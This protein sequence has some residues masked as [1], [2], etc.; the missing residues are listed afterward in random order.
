MH[1]PKLAVI[2]AS[3]F[4]K[5]LIRKGQQLGFEVHAFAWASKDAGEM[6]ADV[7]H[8]ISIV[9]KEAI[10]AV[11]QKESVVA[12]CSIGSDL[13]IHTVNH[14]Q[15]ALGIPCNPPETDLLATNKYEM[16]KAFLAAGVPCPKFM[17]LSAPPSEATLADMRWPLIVKP[18]DRSGSRGIYQCAS[19]DELC[20]AVGF[21]CEQSFEKCAIVEETIAGTEYSCESI[22]FAGEHYALALTK[23]YTTGSPHFIETGHTEPSDI[24]AA[25]QARVK[26]HVKTALDALHI[27]YGASHAE[28]MLD[29]RGGFH[30]IEIGSRMGGDCI[31]SDLVYLSTGMDYM[32]MVI[33]VACAKAPDF[34]PR[35]AP[36]RADIRF[37]FGTEDAKALAE[38]RRNAP[39]SIWRAVENENLSAAVTDSASRHGYYITTGEYL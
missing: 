1:K 24:P 25:L 26:A 31:G 2:G 13:A 8:P 23:K 22:S 18:T 17:K 30:I 35:R 32:R 19:Y 27:C 3:E 36:R 33:D 14:I 29:A 4:Q 12:A 11:C 9:E 28:F 15:R 5:P 34:T 37:L 21:S 10:L 38:L 7:F 39:Q 6:A 16:R 20:A